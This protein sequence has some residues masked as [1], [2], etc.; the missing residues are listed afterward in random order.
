[1]KMLGDEESTG[2]I[3]PG[4]AERVFEQCLFPGQTLILAPCERR[5]FLRVITQDYFLDK[6]AHA[7][8]SVPGIESGLQLNQLTIKP[9][10][11]V[12]VPSS[13]G[14][15]MT[16][17]QPESGQGLILSILLVSASDERQYSRVQG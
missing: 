2:L 17:H 1:M 13:G 11:T 14:L 7:L 3:Q 6:E 15:R 12:L 5:R 4:T 9:G 8:G 16:H 10:S